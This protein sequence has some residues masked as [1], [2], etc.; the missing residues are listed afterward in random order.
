VEGGFMKSLA[1]RNRVFFGLGTVGRDMFYAMVSMFLVYFLTEV[2]D[3]DDATFAAVGGILT[4]LRVFDALNDPI[5]GLV[6]DN[7]KSRWGKFKPWILFG[8][9]TGAV[10]M[11]MLFVDL[12]VS[13]A[14]YIVL[15]TVFYLSWDI[16]Y[17]LNDIAYWSMLPAI[18]L[19]QKQR[20]RVGAFAKICA[21][22]GLFTVVVG[23]LPITGVLGDVVGSLKTGWLV[24]AVAVAVLMI[25]FQLFTLFGVKEMRGDTFKQEEQTTLRDM[26]R[27]IFKNDQLMVATISMGLFM[28]GYVTTTTFGTYF[29]KYAYKDEG[30]YSIFAAVLGVSQ[31]SSYAVFPT[32]SKRFTRRQLYIGATA[33]V[34][35]GYILFFFSPMNMIFIGAAGILLFVGQAFIGMLMLMFLA[36]TIEYGQ[37]KLGR[38]N[39]AV[40]FSIQPLI[41]KIGGAIATGIV[42]VTLIV[43][44]INRAATPADVTA[45]G[46]LIMKL[47]MLILPLLFI[48]AGFVVYRLMYKIDKPF[49]DRM[50]ADLRERGDIKEAG[51]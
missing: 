8:A 19:D 26:V 13:S 47:A 3:L 28:I 1:A 22:I 35:A 50:I 37:W 51:E 48:L 12:G 39:Q 24:F 30:M 6:V 15:F 43:S 36:D 44:G 20:E 16:L 4:G 42:T 40:T 11:V 45:D 23:I 27:A 14:L 21:D 29:F 9:L 34:L 17:G 31:L 7:T 18:T 25:G 38:R 49:Y 41:N 32:L 5:M 10:V 46:L 33:L 2:L